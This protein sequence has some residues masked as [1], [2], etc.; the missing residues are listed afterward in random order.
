MRNIADNNR[1]AWFC[2][3]PPGDTFLGIGFY[4]CLFSGAV[5]VLFDQNA[6]PKLPF[7]DVLR[8]EELVGFC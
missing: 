1:R 2:L 7:A 8:W 6:Q 5:P 3:Q 4:D